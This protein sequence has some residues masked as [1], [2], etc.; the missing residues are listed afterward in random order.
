MQAEETPVSSWPLVSRVLDFEPCQTA[1]RS[2][3]RIPPFRDYALKPKRA[4][5]TEDG[6][7]VA[8]KML[9]NAQ[10]TAGAP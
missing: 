3:T 4:G 6:L 8:F 2:V 7:S 10:G 5:V 9:N 1:A